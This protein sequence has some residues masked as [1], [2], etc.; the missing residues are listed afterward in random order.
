MKN[1]QLVFDSGFYEEG[2][3]GAGLPYILCF[4]PYLPYPFIPLFLPCLPARLSS[5]P[6]SKYSCSLWECC[7]L[8]SGVRSR[9]PAAAAF[10]YILKVETRNRVVWWQLVTPTQLE[11]KTF[12]W[13]MTIDGQSNPV[14]DSSVRVLPQQPT[15]SA[16]TDLCQY[17]SVV[18][19]PLKIIATQ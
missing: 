1:L 11:L 16:Q 10:L 7:K 15:T 14:L 17:T 13:R 18:Y 12:L 3:R 5:H 2:P 19:L 9:T 8:P 4:F 6:A